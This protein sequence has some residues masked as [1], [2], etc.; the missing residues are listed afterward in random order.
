MWQF[1]K[2]AITRIQIIDDRH[3]VCEKRQVIVKSLAF[4]YSFFCFVYRVYSACWCQ[5]KRYSHIHSYDGI[6]I[7]S[8]IRFCSA[9]REVGAQNDPFRT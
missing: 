7:P 3:L 8:K 9:G 6:A 4:L 5:Q 2:V 1:D